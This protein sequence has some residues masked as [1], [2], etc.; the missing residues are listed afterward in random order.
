M[1]RA[2]H[3]KAYR[4]AR[5]TNSRQVI[6]GKRKIRG[7]YLSIISKMAMVIRSSKSKLFLEEQ[8]LSAFPRKELFDWL[9][10][11]ILDGRADSAR[12]IAEIEKRYIFE[13]LDKVPGHGLNKEKITIMFEEKIKRTKIANS[14]PYDELV[15]NNPGF[16]FGKTYR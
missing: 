11:L 13:A 6:E 7:E 16:T 9:R 5:S 12:L 2:E 8:V 15:K 14:K 10:K 1:T 3:R 4:A